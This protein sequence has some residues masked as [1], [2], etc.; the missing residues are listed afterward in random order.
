MPDFRKSKPSTECHR[1]PM[2]IS[3]CDP[4][5]QEKEHLAGS[6]CPCLQTM[7]NSHPLT[8]NSHQPLLPF[9]LPSSLCHCFFCLQAPI[10]GDDMLAACWELGASIDRFS[11]PW[12]ASGALGHS[13][14]ALL[15]IIPLHAYCPSLS[16][17][18]VFSGVFSL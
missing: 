15:P 17:L 4:R 3:V 16:S 9:C 6:C 2:C 5:K 1:S 10:A 8:L 18:F 13:S 11:R 12:E 7:S 14:P